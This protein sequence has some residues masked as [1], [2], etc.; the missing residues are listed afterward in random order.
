[1]QIAYLSIYKRKEILY[2]GFIIERRERDEDNIKSS[3]NQFKA[4]TGRSF[5]KDW[6]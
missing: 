2:Y 5:E 3:T 4:N 6:Y 1:M